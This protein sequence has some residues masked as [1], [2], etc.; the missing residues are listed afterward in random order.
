MKIIKYIKFW[1]NYHLKKDD[2][3]SFSFFVVLILLMVPLVIYYAICIIL[4]WNRDNKV[5]KKDFIDAWKKELLKF[6]TGETK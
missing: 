5:R 6:K 2:G 4:D 3:Q 1:W